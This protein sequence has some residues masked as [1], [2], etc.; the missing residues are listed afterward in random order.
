MEWKMYNKNDRTIESHVRHLVTDGKRIEIAEHA[1][2]IGEAGYTWFVLGGHL[3][4]D[5]THW[6]AIE[7]P[8]EGINK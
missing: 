2:R 6:M 1:R 5:V 8:K 3:A 7:L 4:M